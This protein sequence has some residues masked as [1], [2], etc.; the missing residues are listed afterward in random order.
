VVFAS[1]ATDVVPGD[2]NNQNDV[3]VRSGFPDALVYCTSSST[4]SGC[5]PSLVPN[6]P[7]PSLSAGPGSFVLT[8]SN[9]E[10]VKQGIVFYG[11]SGRLALPWASGSTSFLC[12]KPPT[13]RTGAQNSG[14]SVGQCNGTLAL[15]FFNSCPRTPGA[16]GQPLFAGEV[17][18]AQAWFRDPPAPKTTNLSDAVE[19]T[20]HP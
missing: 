14:G 11:T 5:Q 1:S 2:T 9:V 7:A 17:F 4:T 19:F 10:G 12:V 8:C 3:F 18:D 16:L 15:D 20:L 13:Q 6:Q